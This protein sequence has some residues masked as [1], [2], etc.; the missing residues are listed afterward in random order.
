MKSIAGWASLFVFLFT[1]PS[2]PLPAE[3]SGSELTNRVSAAEAK[4]HLNSEAVV[5]GKVVEI[6]RAEKVVRLNFEK[7]FPYQPFTAVI[8]SNRTN[9]F[10]DLEKLKDKT[11]EVSGRIIEYRR[12]P[13]IILSRTNQLRV[14]D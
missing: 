12:R 7:P 1:F 10:G 13:E 3:E 9:L 14:L 5:R 4:R 11:V 8:F 6:S 2:A